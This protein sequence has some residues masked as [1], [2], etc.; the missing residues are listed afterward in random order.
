MLILYS[1]C[2]LLNPLTVSPEESVSWGT[3]DTVQMQLHAMHLPSAHMFSSV[4]QAFT[5]KT[6]EQNQTINNFKT[7]AAEH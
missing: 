5:H 1:R 3:T 7:A 6:Q 4:P 2:I